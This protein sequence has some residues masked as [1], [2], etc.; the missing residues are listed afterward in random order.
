MTKLRRPEEEASE[1]SASARNTTRW[2]RNSRWRRRWRGA[3]A[4]RLEPGRARSPH[5]DDAKHLARL[6]SGRGR[7]STRTLDAVCQ[8]NRA[9]LKISFEPVKAR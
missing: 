6:E 8:G 1:R 7:P 3:S 2:R 9:P 5:E 4:R